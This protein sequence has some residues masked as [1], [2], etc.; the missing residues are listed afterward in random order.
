MLIIIASMP[1][2]LPLEI[3]FSRR[4]AN[5]YNKCKSHESQLVQTIIIVQSSTVYQKM[6]LFSKA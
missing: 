5:F 2:I 3:Q 6:N 4:F 1:E